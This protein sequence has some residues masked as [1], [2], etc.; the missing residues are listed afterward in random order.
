[1]PSIT[2]QEINKVSLLLGELNE[3]VRR[4]GDEEINSHWAKYACLRAC[5]AME[6]CLRNIFNEVVKSQSKGQ[7]QNY[8]IKRYSREFGS[9]NLERI[10]KL[11]EGFDPKWKKRI[12]EDLDEEKKESIS[13]I[14]SN[15]HTLAH[16]LDVDLTIEKLTMWWAAAEGFVNTI[17]DITLGGNPP[18]GDSS[19]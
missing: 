8:I 11:L 19:A 3:R 9:A 12:M 16:G 4:I 5:G 13:S 7:T 6:V 17:R 10:L 14:F 2:E 18:N 1:M 15:R